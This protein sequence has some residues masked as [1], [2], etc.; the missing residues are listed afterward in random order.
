[1]DSSLGLS[2]LQQALLREFFRREHRFVLTGGGAL[3]GFHL[4]HRTSKDLDLFAKPPIELA[5]GRRALEAAAASLGATVEAVRTFPEFQRMLIRTGDDSVLVDLAIDRTPDVDAI[6]DHGG[7]RVHSLREIAA[8]KLCAILGRGEIRDLIDLRAILLRG[9]DLRA[10]LVDAERK[11]GGVSAATLA[12]VLDSVRIGDT[13]DGTA[14]LPADVRAFELEQFRV[15]LV[16][17]LR[18]LAL[19]GA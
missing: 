11:D 2:T 13:V 14:E 8:N 7:I 6:E 1:M 9:F 12:W 19:P 3:V 18:R 17:R 10:V 5:D 16:Q 4:H 15:E